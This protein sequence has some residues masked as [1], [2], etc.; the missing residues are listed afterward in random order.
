METGLAALLASDAT[1]LGSVIS[2]SSGEETACKTTLHNAT[3]ETKK[4][5]RKI[6]SARM[7]NPRFWVICTAGVL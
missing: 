5:P 2:R 6:L 7:G 3:A 1:D 4:I